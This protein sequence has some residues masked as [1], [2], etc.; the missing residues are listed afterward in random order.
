[1][2][3]QAVS[4]APLPLRPTPPSSPAGSRPSTA[5]GT[6]VASSSGRS[7]SRWPKCSSR[8]AIAPGGFVAAYVLDSKWGID[9]GFDTYF[10]DF[11]LSRTGPVAGRDSAARQRGRG[12]GAAVDSRSSRDAV[13]R[14]DPSLRC[15][16]ALRSAGALQVALPRPSLPRR[17]RVR[18]LAG[19]TRRLAAPSSGLFDRTIIVVMG[20]HGESLGDHGEAPTGSSSTTASPMCRW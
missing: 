8:A 15:A 1:M 6:T 16:L 18:R 19:R 2:F 4:V 20:D 11:D 17:N 5:F 9:Q 3:E 7:S 12:P 10:D 14:L 13:L